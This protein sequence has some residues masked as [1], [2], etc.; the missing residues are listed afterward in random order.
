M[1]EPV[2]GK[3]TPAHLQRNAYL[4]VRQSTLQQ[5]MANTESSQRQYQLRQRALALG[6]HSDQIVVIDC[7]Q[8]QSGASSADREGFQQLV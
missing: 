2:H 1:S 8:G 5:V 6:W 3:V 7:D 4:Y